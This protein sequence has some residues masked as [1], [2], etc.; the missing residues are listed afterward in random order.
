LGARRRPSASEK[1]N[2]KIRR[3]ILAIFYH[4]AYSS[5]KPLVLGGIYIDIC[6]TLLL[7]W[8]RKRNNHKAVVQY[9]T[10]LYSFLVASI[11]PSSDMDEGNRRKSC[12]KLNHVWRLVFA[13]EPLGIGRSNMVT[14]CSRDSCAALSISLSTI[15]YGFF[16]VIQCWGM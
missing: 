15:S 1:W 2:E 9:S 12:L 8:K 13:C 3:R 11:S 4:Q 16:F 14:I 5:T 7:L 10:F 6:P